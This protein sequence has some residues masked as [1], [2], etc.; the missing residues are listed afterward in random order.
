MS[1]K[2]ELKWLAALSDDELLVRLSDASKQSRR[3]EAVLVAHIAEVDAR[4]LYAREAL[5]SM[6][7][8][9]TDV[10]HL[11]EADAYRRITAARLSRRFP[12]LLTMLEDGRIHL[13]GIAVISKHLTEANY[14]K[15]LA[16]ATHKSRRALEELVAE[17]V[18]KPDVPPTIRKTPQPKVQL[19]SS[20]SSDELCPGR[21]EELGKMPP[22]TPPAA[23]EKRPTVAPL[24]P[25]RY[26]VNFTASAALR[27]KL[28]RLEALIPGSDLAS[29]IDAAVSEKLERLEA[30]RFGKTKNPRTHAKDADTSPGVRGI[31]AA[32]KRFVWARDGGQCTYVNYNGRRCPERHRLEYHH[33]DPYGRGGDRSANNIRL[34]CKCHNLYMAELDF[35]KEKMDPYRRAADRVGEPRRRLNSVQ[36]ELNRPLMLRFRS[37]LKHATWLRGNRDDFRDVVFPPPGAVGRRGT[38]AE[39]VLSDGRIHKGKAHLRLVRELLQSIVDQVSRARAR[40]L[41]LEETEASVEL[42]DFRADLAVTPSALST[43]TSSPSLGAPFGKQKRGKKAARPASLATLSAWSAQTIRDAIMPVAMAWQ[44]HLTRRSIDC[45]IF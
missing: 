15:V 7:R 37:R 29:I 4:R 22:P 26:Q 30:K 23:T 20:K 16:K 41:S 33:D 34:M 8:F 44:S 13:C 6:F 5:P 27:D 32:V 31:A 36:A 21:V 10:L 24:S 45:K 25:A 3:G 9:C 38:D 19:K 35:G 28:E 11:S 18:P 12:V 17:L 1:T 14:E 43:A 2:D 42:A 40:S 39:L